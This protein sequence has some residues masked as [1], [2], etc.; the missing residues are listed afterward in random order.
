M[1]VRTDH[2][3]LV[4]TVNDNARKREYLYS[5]LIALQAQIVSELKNMRRSTEEY[6]SK[7]Q[8]LKKVKA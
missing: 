6:V 3:N 7:S 1:S 8:E 5:G 4:V 2:L